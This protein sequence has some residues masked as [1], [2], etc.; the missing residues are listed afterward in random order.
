[1]SEGLEILKGAREWLSD[2]EH[3]I[4]GK[5]GPGEWPSESNGPTCAVGAIIRVG[6]E[7]DKSLGAMSKAELNL[8]EV[9][10]GGGIIL[11]NDKPDTTH[12]C[13]LAAFDAAIEKAEKEDL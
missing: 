3:W 13:I 7:C 6:R 2:P 5:I 12:E 9:V 8:N 10:P 11:Y 4:K 1:M